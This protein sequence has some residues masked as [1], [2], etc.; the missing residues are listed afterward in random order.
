MCECAFVG[1]GIV[2]AD[3][4]DW[5]CGCWVEADDYA[6]GWVF[7]AGD[8]GYE[9]WVIGEIESGD[10]VVW[11]GQSLGLLWLWKIPQE[12]YESLTRGGLGLAHE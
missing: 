2:E 1:I 8:I 6:A 10:G 5:L 11:H 9:T 7:I 3:A 12:C 4:C